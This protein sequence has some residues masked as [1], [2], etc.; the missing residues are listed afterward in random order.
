MR[1]V[2]LFVSCSTFIFGA[3]WI[4]LQ[5]FWKYHDYICMISCNLFYIQVD[6]FPMICHKFNCIGYLD[7]WCSCPISLALL[8]KNEPGHGI[9]FSLTIDT[10]PRPFG[11]IWNTI[12]HHTMKYISK[13]RKYDMLLLCPRILIEDRIR[14]L[15]MIFCTMLLNM[16]VDAGHCNSSCMYGVVQ[17][18]IIIPHVG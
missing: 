5:L 18:L 7:Q 12:T 17:L 8:F 11:W 9:G 6:L 14:Y 15:Q 13:C 3:L 16:P 4:I 10:L 2:G 1:F